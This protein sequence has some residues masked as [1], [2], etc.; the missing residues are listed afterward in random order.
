MAVT[1]DDRFLYALNSNSGVLDRTSISAFRIAANGA[2]T[3]LPGSP[4][5]SPGLVNPSGA[6][7]SWDGKFLSVSF[8]NKA[9][10]LPDPGAVAMF[11]IGSNGALTLV[12]GSPFPPGGDEFGEIRGPMGPD[13]DCG[14]RFNFVM[15]S[16][17]TVHNLVDVSRITSNGALRPV[18]GSPFEFLTRD[19]GGVLGVLSP[20]DRFLF[21]SNTNTGFEPGVIQGGITVLKVASNGR[22]T[23]VPGSPFAN[24]GGHDPRGMATNRAGTLLYAANF[25]NTV[26]GFRVARNGTLTPVPGSPF[27]TT[28]IPSA[29]L[30]SLTVYPAKNC[31]LGDRGHDDDH[32]GGDEDD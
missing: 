10:D 18:P 23:M 27:A 26:S 8:F 4:F 21:V 30:S 24:P 20:D 13:I 31:G 25:N 15:L 6:K 7:V 5:P 28:T 14:N 29:G 16:T 12:P 17:M 1:P 32:G 2:L 11:R 3:P 9:G 22:L 19:L